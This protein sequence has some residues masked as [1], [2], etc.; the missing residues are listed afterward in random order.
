MRLKNSGQVPEYDVL[1]PNSTKN[2]TGQKN[3]DLEFKKQYD[4]AIQGRELEMQNEL[5]RLK[6]E[7]AEIRVRKQKEE[8]NLTDLMKEIELKK[9]RDLRARIEKEQI[10]K[11]IMLLEKNKLSSLEQEKKA[12]LEKLAG[13]REMLKKKEDHLMNELAR[14]EDDMRGLDEIRNQEMDKVNKNAELLK[15]KGRENKGVNEILIRER[16]DK[17]AELKMRR[18]QL[19]LERQRIMGDLD[20]IK[21]GETVPKRSNYGLY[22]ANQMLNEMNAMKNYGL[23]EARDKFQREEDRINQLRVKFFFDIME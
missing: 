14:L 16:S 2:D 12:S 19:D 4:I 22:A 10:K 7:K 5:D 17:I 15:Q 18:E 11:E 1:K 23:G 8:E 6:K 13:E 3:Y 21:K 20:K 9:E